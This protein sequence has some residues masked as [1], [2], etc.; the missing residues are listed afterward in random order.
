MKK[1][2]LNINSDNNIN[3]IYNIVVVNVNENIIL[4]KNSMIVIWD[5]INNLKINRIELR[6]IIN[7]I[8]YTIY[9][10]NYGI[11]F[12]PSENISIST[13]YGINEEMIV[14]NI[15]ECIEYSLYYVFK[16]IDNKIFE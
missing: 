16:F 15:K 3:E 8:K 11:Y 9:I 14:D 5:N 2:T 4:N 10:Y 13:I 6:A 1:Y 7:N 12:S